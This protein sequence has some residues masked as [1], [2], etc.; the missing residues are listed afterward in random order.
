MLRIGGW[1]GNGSP[2]GGESQPLRVDPSN[3]T[4]RARELRFFDFE[5]NA[6]T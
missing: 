2:A 5:R 6:P 3:A 4:C 1:R